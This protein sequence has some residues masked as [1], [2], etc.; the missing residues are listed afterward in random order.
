MVP[1]LGR[2]VGHAF[3]AT[4]AQL[5]E[6][7]VVETIARIRREYF[8]KGK[9]IKEI[10]RDLKVL[11]DMTRSVW[12]VIPH[13]RAPRVGKR[14]KRE[15]VQVLRLLEVFRAEDVLAGVRD[16]LARGMIGFDAVKYL[17][18]CRIERRPPRLDLT[19]YP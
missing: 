19:V 10:V 9:S 3:S 17:T 15:F 5:W 16:A 11:R 6:M 18:L 14:G 13:A 8:V 2:E 4:V 12:R 7:L 1:T